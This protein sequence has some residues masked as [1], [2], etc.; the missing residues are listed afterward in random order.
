MSLHLIPN[1][2]PPCVPP[3]VTEEGFRRV[4]FEQRRP[5]PIQFAESEPEPYEGEPWA[6]IDAQLSKVIYACLAMAIF[7]TACAIAGYLWARLG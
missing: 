2:A 6:W 5:M 3:P 1:N 4:E 7:V